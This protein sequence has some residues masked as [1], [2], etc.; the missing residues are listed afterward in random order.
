MHTATSSARAR[1]ILT[2]DD[3]LRANELIVEFAQERGG[4]SAVFVSMS[5]EQVRARQARGELVGQEAEDY[6]QSIKE[7]MTP[8]PE[9]EWLEFENWLN[10]RG[11][12]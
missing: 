12:R 4:W 8:G 1:D 10:A 11:V 5:L 7:R 6:V 2:V 9:G 3:A